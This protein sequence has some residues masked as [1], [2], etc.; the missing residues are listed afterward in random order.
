MTAS[1]VIAERSLGVPRTAI[2][3]DTKALQLAAEIL[4]FVKSKPDD[5]VVILGALEVARV[6]FSRRSI[7]ETSSLLAHNPTAVTAFTFKSR[8]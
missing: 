5:D 8:P 3:A 4:Q 2:D 7:P 1:E 6:V